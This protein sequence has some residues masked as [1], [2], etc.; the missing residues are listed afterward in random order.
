MS[1]TASERPVSDAVLTPNALA[2]SGWN[3]ESSLCRMPI[4]SAAT[5]VIA[6]D[7]NRPTSAAASA[8]RIGDRQDRAFSVTIG[9]SRIA[10]SADRNPAITM[11]D[12]LDPVRCPPRDRRDPAV[13]GDGRRREP[14]QRAA[15]DGAQHRPR[16][17]ARDR[18]GSAGPAVMR[19]SPKITIESI[20]QQ[21]RAARSSWS[22]Q[23]TSIALCAA[24]SSASVAI[25]RLSKR[26]L[27]QHAP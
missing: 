11:V 17:R 26:R 8:G 5:T 9:A 6:N 23:I 25:S 20:G 22:G 3:S 15:V 4:P 16:A 21:R 2:M 18:S 12:E 10:A 1:G 27:A 19:R 13:L 14:E 24:L 7:E